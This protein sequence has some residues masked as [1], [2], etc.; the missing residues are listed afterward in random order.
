MMPPISVIGS[1]E[2]PS[3]LACNGKIESGWIFN[4]ERNV[5]GQTFIRAPESIIEDLV[6]DLGHIRLPLDTL[7]VVKPRLL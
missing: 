1:E 5:S 2:A 4:S 6:T 7:V 3:I